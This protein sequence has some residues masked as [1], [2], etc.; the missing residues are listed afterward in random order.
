MSV[1]LFVYGSLKRGGRHHDQLEGAVFLGEVETAAGYALEPVGEYLALVA[2]AGAPNVS[3]ELFEISESRLPA[4]DIFEGEA[5]FRGEVSLRGAAEAES[6]SGSERAL[7][8]F[9]KPR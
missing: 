5:Y 3:G 2:L 9:K 7:A 6:L 8:Y 4:L 1:H